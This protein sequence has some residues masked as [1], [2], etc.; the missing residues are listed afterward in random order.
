MGMPT[1]NAI[2][3][4]SMTGFARVECEDEGWR[5]SWE[6]KSV[7][8]RGLE[9]RL[10]LP[11][12]FDRLEPLLKKAAAGVFSRGNISAG[13]T[14]RSETGVAGVKINKAALDAALEG[15]RGVMAAIP[16]DN[17]RPEGVLA[18]RGV[19]EAD[20]Q[21]ISPD[22]RDALDKALQN[23]FDDALVALR[24][25][26][27][28]EGAALGGVLNA[29]VDQIAALVLEAK[30]SA[31]TTPDLIRARL[32]TQLAE[33]LNDNVP[34]DRLAQ[35]AALL[36]VKADVREEL[37]RLDAHIS[38]ARDLLA[39]PKPV[40]RRLDFLTQ[41]FNRE[42]NTLCAKANDIGLKQIGLSLKTVVDQLREQV[43]N[44]E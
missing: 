32:E 22:A 13:L 8:G 30:A 16:C 21:A 42:A 17:P 36:A 10:R 34:E 11:Q 43:Q 12:G 6:L 38:A 24:E 44:V 40:G 20:D 2:A 19:M 41:E 15:V 27:D 23:S 29:Q 35:E 18:L 37:D 7:N 39:D 25:A 4:T 14:L 5:W 28:A 26:R 31:A 9:T 33:L 1:D 3:I